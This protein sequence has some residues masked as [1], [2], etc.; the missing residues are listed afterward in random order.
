VQ[1]KDWTCGPGAA[2]GRPPGFRLFRTGVQR[3]TDRRQEADW[4][5]PWFCRKI[6]SCSQSITR[7]LANPSHPPLGC[8][9]GAEP[10]QG[11][12]VTFTL[13]RPFHR[14]LMPRTHPSRTAVCGIMSVARFSV[15]ASICGSKMC[16]RRRALERSECLQIP[17]RLWRL[18]NR[19]QTQMRSSP[20]PPMCRE[21]MHQLSRNELMWRR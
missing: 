9:R 13:R 6:E 18:T 19:L 15:W 8:S 21:P 17:L 2:L 12:S 11:M 4:D 20:L 7:A 14:I 16:H 5:Q 1:I 10:A 3:L